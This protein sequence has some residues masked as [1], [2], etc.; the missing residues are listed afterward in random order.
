MPGELPDQADVWKAIDIYIPI[1]YEGKEPPTTVRSLL[2]LLRSWAGRFY[3]AP[4]F[5]KTGEP[6]K[7]R[8]SIRLGNVRYPHMKLALELSPDG[9]KYLFKADTHDRH[10][11]P[12]SS[13]P[14]YAAFCEL[15]RV[16]QE[17][18]EQIEASWAKQGLLTFKTYLEADLARRHAQAAGKP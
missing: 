12:P 18:A 11:C 10:I 15:M 13:S 5:A 8:Y 2:A 16:N 17:I 14:E 1:A 3:E 6:I 7:T 4:A 9:E